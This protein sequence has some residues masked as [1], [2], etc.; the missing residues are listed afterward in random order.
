MKN[1]KVKNYFNPTNE[2]EV[3]DAYFPHVQLDKHII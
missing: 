2:K 1:N 3:F